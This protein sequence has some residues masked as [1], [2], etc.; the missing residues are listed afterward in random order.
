MR[1]SAITR[2][3]SSCSKRNKHSNP[4]PDIMQRKTLKRV[5][6]NGISPS[7]PQGS[8]N[9]AEEKVERAYEREGIEDKETRV[10]ISTQS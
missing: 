2:E 5:S 8:G 9:L 4:Q 3:T 1:G 6:L 7:S 10:S